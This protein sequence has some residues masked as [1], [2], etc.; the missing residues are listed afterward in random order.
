MTKDQI[1]KILVLIGS[2]IIAGCTEPVVQPISTE[3]ENTKA[4]A[5]DSKIEELKNYEK[6]VSDYQKAQQLEV[7]ESKSSQVME[8]SEVTTSVKMR[9]IYPVEKSFPFPPPKAST[10]VEIK[11]NL[12]FADSAKSMTLAEV[13]DTLDQALTKAGYVEKSYYQVPDGFALVTRLEKINEDGSP[14]PEQARWVGAKE[15]QRIFSISD[16]LKQLFTANPGYYRIIVFIVTSQSFSQDGKQTVSREE[17]M[18][19]L[20]EGNLQ[21]PES[22]AQKSY[23]KQH[24]CTA[25]VYQFERPNSAAQETI[26][27]TPSSVPATSHLTRSGLF[28]GLQ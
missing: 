15:K 12:L 16:Y 4:V 24:K 2:F 20:T 1:I 6:T 23:T 5:L 13:N 3:N 8:R 9:P 19:W 25:L 17:A 26:L 11:R 21:L 28:K 14:K 7:L 22:I 10:Y 18:N 27:L